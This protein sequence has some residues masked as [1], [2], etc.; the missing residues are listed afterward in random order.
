MI[1]KEIRIKNFRSYYG[2][3][4]HIEVTPGLTL[5]LGD[6]GDGKTTFFEALQWLFNTTTEKGNL[7][8]MSEMRKSKLEIGEQ[9]EV[10][11]FM[12]FDHDGEKSVEKSFTVEKVDEDSFK[13]GSLVYRGYETV[14]S[15]RVQ[16]SGK[17]LINRCYDAFIQRFSMF[18]GESELNVFENAT[19]LKDLVDKFSDIRKFDN[20]V[21]YTSDFEEKSNSAYVKEMKSD[22]KVAGEAKV[23]ESQINRLSERIFETKRDINDKKTSLEV[24]SKR[25]GEL[26]ENQETSERYKDIQSRLKNK[27]DKRNKLKAQIGRIDYSHALLDKM[28]ILCPF[29]DILQDYKQ[30]CSAL[31]KEKRLQE[32][33]YDRQKAVEIGKLQA[34]KEMQNALENGTPELPWYLPNQETMEE[35]LHDHICKVCGRPAEEGSEAY[36][37]MLHKLEE[38]K[39]HIALEP[40]RK[41]QQEKIE[42][43]ELFKFN[44]IEDLHN[45]SISL[46][47]SNE[48]RIAGIAREI[49]DWRD[50]V[51]RWTQ[52]LKAVEEQIQDIIDEKSRLLIQAGN[53]SEAILEKDFNDIKGL[54]EQKG[55]AEVRLTELNRD[56][57]Q[58]QKQMD[59]LQKQMDELNPD[60]SQVKVFREVHRVMESIAKAV[61]VAKS[62]NLRRFLAEMEEKANN[63]L[64]S[65]SADDF[66]GEIHLR[67]TADNST[68]IRLFSAN[69]TEVRKPSGSQLTVM[70]IS[71]LFAIS[72][73][74]QEKRD[75]D[76]PLI[77]DAATSSFGDSK[78]RG[79]YNVIDGLHKQC[80]IITKDFISNGRVD[81]EKVDKLTCSVYRIKK[82]DGFNAKNMATIRTTIEK[83][84]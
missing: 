32:K 41:T 75:E 66:H 68:E 21:E 56:L 45:L 4:N 40:E 81:I 58:M 20:L 55:R 74:T 31:S 84:K 39:R 72:D 24:F 12:S 27:E 57:E 83:L 11:V 43:Q 54:F 80:I 5:I 15:E 14:G 62:E 33:N 42:D 70:Y 29:P 44:Y 65:L 51:D 9:D 1:I 47:G 77:F 28:W 73:F 26:E 22:K 78:E 19:A 49:C 37:F 8:H 17:T 82:A 48:S 76:Y 53:V 16:V 61:A 3:N 79:F 25:L 10:S 18:K 36:K 34:V 50:L 7:D 6:N 59:G 63:Y 52:D 69:G 71:V 38:Y 2:D 13:V 46:S 30:K 23:L 35:M 64:A 67:Q 60:S